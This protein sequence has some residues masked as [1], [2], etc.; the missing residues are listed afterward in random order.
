MKIKYLAV[1]VA[2][3]I[4]WILGGVWYGVLFT[5]KFI[6]L[7]GWDQAK[8]QQM[9]SQGPGKELGIAFIMSLVLC[10]ILA[11]FIQYAKAKSAM[12]GAQVAF[13]LWLG[14]IVTTNIATVLFEERPMGLYLINIGYQFVACVIAGVILAVWRSREP[15]EAVPA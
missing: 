11:H 5:N 9:E 3:I 2:A 15:V 13:W 4:H 12:G 14:F 7:I 10:Y 6:Q 8:L 1:L